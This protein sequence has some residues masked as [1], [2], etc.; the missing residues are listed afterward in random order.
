M[1]RTMQCLPTC[2]WYHATPQAEALFAGCYSAQGTETGTMIPIITTIAEDP[3]DHG[4]PQLSELLDAQHVNVPRFF[5]YHGRTG[6]V[7][8]FPHEFH[9][10]DE[11]HSEYILLWAIQAN[12]AEDVYVAKSMIK[13]LQSADDAED[14]KDERYAWR[15][16]GQEQEDR[17]KIVLEEME[18]IAHEERPDE[19]DNE[20]TQ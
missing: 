1:L 6:Q 19:P 8:F 5:T 4:V 16:W 17:L 18:Q 2:I 15:K 20:N 13:D 3:V 9:S 12:L 14:T 10:E 11:V 7:H